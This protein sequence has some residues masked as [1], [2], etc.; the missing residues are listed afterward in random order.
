MISKRSIRQTATSC[1]GFRWG[2]LPAGR[3]G[4]TAGINLFYNSKLYE[5][6]T[7]WF[8]VENESCEMVGEPPDAVLVCPYYQKSVL[9][10]SPEGGWQFG[11]TYWLKLVDRHDQYANVPTEKQPQCSLSSPGYYEWRY[12]YKLI[13]VMP[14]GSSHEMRPNGWSDGNGND[15]RCTISVERTLVTVTP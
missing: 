9:A 1:C 13:L 15:P 11:S 4:L 10:E 6:Q 3:N 2:A 14:D 7:Q 8:A 12:R 5:S